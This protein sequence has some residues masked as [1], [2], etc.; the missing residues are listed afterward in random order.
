MPVD[1]KYMYYVAFDLIWKDQKESAKMIEWVV[2]MRNWLT[3]VKHLKSLIMTNRRLL[4]LA[5]EELIMRRK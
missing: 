4:E 5:A 3:D 2:T 1:I